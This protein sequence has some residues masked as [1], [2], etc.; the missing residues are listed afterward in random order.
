VVSIRVGVH[1]R[2]L[3]GS[4]VS[5][6][7]LEVPELDKPGRPRGRSLRA[8]SARAV[9]ALGDRPPSSANAAPER[10]GGEI[11]ITMVDPERATR[12]LEIV[13]EKS[14]H[15]VELAGP[16]AMP[17]HPPAA[18]KDSDWPLLER[19]V[20]SLTWPSETDWGAALRQ[21]I[22]GFGATGGGV[23][24]MTELGSPAFLFSCGEQLGQSACSELYG[25]F[26]RYWGSASLSDQCLS[27]SFGTA[28]TFAVSVLIKSSN[29]LLGV[30]VWGGDG[31]KNRDLTLLRVFARLLSGNILP[32]GAPAEGRRPA[33]RLLVPSAF[34]EGYVIGQS[35]EMDEVH[36]EVASISGSAL[37]VL[38][39]GET[40]VG[41]EH[42]AHMVHAWS[43]RSRGPFVAVNGAAIPSELL[44]AE[45]FGIGKGVATGVAGRSGYMQM[46]HG[47]TLFLDEVGDM[48]LHLQ[49]KMLRALQDKE[50]RQVGGAASRLDVRLVAA[51]N[52]DLQSK[53]REGTF[54]VDLYYR[55]AGGIIHVPPLRN[56]KEDI[57][58]LLQFFV[59]QAARE[60]G[61]SLRGITLEAIEALTAYSWPGNT[62]ELAHIAQRLVHLCEDGQ[63]ISTEMIPHHIRYAG[64]PEPAV[65]GA[66]A[67]T[68]DLRRRLEEL[69]AYLIEQALARARGNRTRAAKL[70]GVSR[71]GLAIKMERLSICYRLHFSK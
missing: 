57:P 26:L 14:I 46:A 8:F 58:D 60:A 10:G 52:S 63:Y 47:G 28:P 12:A 55:L 27:A 16:S 66:H 1:A 41:K 32:W 15:K 30:A 13:S 38:I 45:M 44:E 22:G 40:G 5:H 51:T 6:T 11:A 61:R 50:V 59:R 70:L 23:G 20:E 67:D 48:P 71:G 3:P 43:P 34:P 68:L 37:P 31:L 25:F 4:L 42:I 17:E 29:E 39:I 18:L 36:K 19:L 69:E 9:D 7:D 33:R 54:R 65:V 24:M 49:A 21:L 2:S 35:K 62:R 56:R 64:R 53:V